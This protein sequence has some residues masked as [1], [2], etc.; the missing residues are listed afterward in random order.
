[1]KNWK[2]EK[3]DIQGDGQSFVQRIRITRNTEEPFIVVSAGLNSSNNVVELAHRIAFLL[4]LSEEPIEKILDPTS[5]S[6]HGF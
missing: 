3:M 5:D 6:L 1:M 2:A 4:N